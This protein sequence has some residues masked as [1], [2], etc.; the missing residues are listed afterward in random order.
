MFGFGKNRKIESEM[1]EWLSHPNEF[2]VA[3][4]WVRHKRSYKC[5]LAGDGEMEI[6]LMEY[7]MPDGTQSRGFVNPP[8]TWSFLGDVSSIGD[9]ELLLAYCGW[10][11]LFPRIQA[12]TVLT[13]FTSDGEEARFIAQKQ[14]QG[15]SDVNITGRFKIGTSQVFEFEGVSAGELTK[16]AGDTESDMSFA[17]THPCYNLPSI[18][19]FLGRHAVKSMKRGRDV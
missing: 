14:A 18:Y 8:L 10:A 11:W 12:G 3:P 9:E 16:G 2:G 4:N 17:P 6:H 13:N 15:V 19:F 5:D 1:A 7:E